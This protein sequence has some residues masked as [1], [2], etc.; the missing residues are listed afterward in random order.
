MTDEISLDVVMARRFELVEAQ[1]ALALKHKAEMAPIAEELKL[2]ELFVKDEMNK[3]GAQQYKTQAAGHMAFFTTK[4]S[5]TVKDMDASIR[6]MLASTPPL[7]D[8]GKT[9][10]AGMWAKV[11]DHICANGMWGLLNKAVNKTAAKE[12]LDTGVSPATLGVEYSSYKDLAWRRG[13]G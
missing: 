5:V 1:E 2:C 12:I 11:I 3:L 4:D 10:D 13:K 7:T 9:V 6:Y 8:A